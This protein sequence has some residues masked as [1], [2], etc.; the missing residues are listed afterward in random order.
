MQDPVR[1]K[2]KEGGLVTV[3]RSFAE[4]HELKVLEDERAVGFDG[5]AL[6]DKPAESVDEAAAKKGPKS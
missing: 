2:L 4:F 6:A 1:A 5:R 3:E